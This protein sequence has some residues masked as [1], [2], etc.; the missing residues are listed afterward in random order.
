MKINFYTLSLDHVRVN[1]VTSHNVCVLI[2]FFNFYLKR[3]F[4]TFQSSR[5]RVTMFLVKKCVFY[6]NFRFELTK[7]TKFRKWIRKKCYQKHFTNKHK[8]NLK[9]EIFIT[10]LNCNEWN[11][12]NCYFLFIV[13]ILI[14]F[15]INFQNLRFIRE[16]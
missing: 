3:W 7:N 14:L 2:K 6:T 10:N 12:V 8:Y 9:I 11:W 1:F 13:K 5:K 16:I 15:V 4:F